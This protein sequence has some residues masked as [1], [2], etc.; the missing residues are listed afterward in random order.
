[1]NLEEVFTQPRQ[2]TAPTGG[3]MMIIENHKAQTALLETKILNVSSKI[4]FLTLAQNSNSIVFFYQ[5]M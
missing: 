1:M 2:N 5:G 4:V 3:G